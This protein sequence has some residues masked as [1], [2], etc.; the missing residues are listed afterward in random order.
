MIYHIC[1]SCETT[2]ADTLDECPECG[3]EK[4]TYL[5]VEEPNDTPL[6]FTEDEFL[7]DET[8]TDLDEYW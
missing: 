7:E 3:S 5:E 4:F 2:Y 1:A 6:D 8:D